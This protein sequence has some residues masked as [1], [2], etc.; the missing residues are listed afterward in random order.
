MQYFRNALV[1][2]LLI[3]LTLTARSERN[4]PEWKLKEIQRKERVQILVG[5]LTEGSDED[6]HAAYV[7]LRDTVIRKRDIPELIKQ[8]DRSVSPEAKKRLQGLI[9]LMKDES[10]LPNGG[11]TRDHTECHK[12][13]EREFERLGCRS[14][15]SYERGCPKSVIVLTLNLFDFPAR[16]KNR[17]DTVGLILDLDPKALTLWNGWKDVSF[18]SALSDLEGLTL[19][20]TSVTDLTPLKGLTKLKQLDIAFSPV[21]ELDP[22]KGLP[23][24]HVLKLEGT[25]VTNLTPLAKLRSLVELHLDS[26]EMID[27]TPLDGMPDLNVFKISE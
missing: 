18:L 23:S 16:A 20:F 6:R 9:S 13:Y 17:A 7:D 19:N 25:N 14:I 22:L 3:S 11:W 27:L 8:V 1:F 5:S 12:A 24:L 15:V 26:A 21:D 2:F 4:E 10:R